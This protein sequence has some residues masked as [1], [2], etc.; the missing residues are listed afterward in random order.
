MKMG[1]AR[2][3]LARNLRLLR[4]VR[5]WSQERL[6]E[7][8]GLDRSYVSDIERATR[9]VSVEILERLAGAFGVSLPE[10]LSE[11]NPIELGEGL[12]NAYSGDITEN[13]E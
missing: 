1:G 5:G 10:L 3:L 2:K 13:K 9:N 8:A 4:L 11:P 7:E 6:A 12:L